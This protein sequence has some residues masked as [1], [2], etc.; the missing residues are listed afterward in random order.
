MKTVGKIKDL[1]TELMTW[2]GQTIGFIPTMGCL[3]MGHISLVKKAKEQCDRVVVSVFVNP[4][5]FN[6]SHDFESY[7]KNL[8]D[9]EEKLKPYGVDLIFAPSQSEMY[10]STH[11][12]STVVPG[13]LANGLCGNDRPGHFTGVATVVL[14][15]LNIIT[16]SK[17]Y[18]GKKDYQQYL[19]IK[20]MVIDLNMDVEVIGVETLRELD[21][22]AMSSRNVHLNGEQRKKANMI[23]EQLLILSQKINKTKT[24]AIRAQLIKSWQALEEAGFE[25]DYLSICNPM[26]LEEIEGQIN[27]P[28]VVLCAARI[29]STRLIDNLECL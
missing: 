7:P 2:Q 29:G 6:E 5:Q 8:Q 10:G 21:G 3:H 28:V 23:R 15:L 19:I 25:V 13:A 16:P 17:I 14:K 11:N 22:L 26:T 27:K 9:D 18:M 20:Q 12:Q 4:T 24:E 1:K